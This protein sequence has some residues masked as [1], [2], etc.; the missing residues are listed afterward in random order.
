[1]ELQEI[2]NFQRDLN[3]SQKLEG[4]R[5]TR[6]EQEKEALQGL[7]EKLQGSIQTIETQAESEKEVLRDENNYLKQ[8]LTH[9]EERIKS[10]LEIV[11]RE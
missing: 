11:Q 2:Q 5:A 9:R 4:Q 1:M 8:A 6:L 10:D 7:I 3:D